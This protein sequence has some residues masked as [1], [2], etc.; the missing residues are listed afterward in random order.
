MFKDWEFISNIPPNV[1]PCFYDKSY[2]NAN[3][4]FITFKRR[5]K[6]EKGEKGVIYITKL[7]ENTTEYKNSIDVKSLIKLK[8][9]LEKSLKGLNNLVDTY[10]SDCQEE[11]SKSYKECFN[12]V[13]ILIEK[14]SEKLSSK[15]SFFCHTPKIELNVYK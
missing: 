8:E 11:I 15:K 10:K 3:E 5:Y 12:K 13:E 9:T 4:W 6:G 2:I 1:K 14:I 7:I